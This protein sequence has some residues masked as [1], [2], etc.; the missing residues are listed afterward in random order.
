MA[1]ALHLRAAVPALL[2]AGNLFCLNDQTNI[3]CFMIL[4]GVYHPI[5]QSFVYLLLIDIEILSDIIERLN[6][7]HLL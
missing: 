1:V 4:R 3:A 7:T 6:D 2:Q 5:F